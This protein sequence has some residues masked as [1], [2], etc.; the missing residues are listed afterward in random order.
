MKSSASLEASRPVSWVGWPLLEYGA[1]AASGLQ[2][3]RIS[4]IR[5]E[6]VTVRGCDPA[7]ICPCWRWGG[8]PIAWPCLCNA[9][10]THSL[11]GDRG[12]EQPLSRSDLG[13]NSNGDRHSPT[14]LSPFDMTGLP[15]LWE[16]KESIPKLDPL[17]D[18][19]IVYQRNWVLRG[20]NSNYHWYSRQIQVERRLLRWDFASIYP[21]GKSKDVSEIT[22]IHPRCFS[23][24]WLNLYSWQNGKISRL[25]MLHK[26]CIQLFCPKYSTLHKID[27]AWC[28]SLLGSLIDFSGS[29]FFLFFRNENSSVRFLNYF[30]IYFKYWQK[31]A[32]IRGSGAPI[33]QGK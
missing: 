5:K 13:L 3:A 30:S 26:P 1:Q 23:S 12:E 2:S 14:K 16:S 17:V 33:V 15:G 8:N 28:Y 4:L 31:T 32:L 24:S 11:L 6:E 7:E 10:S 18:A 19:S 22:N 25:S 27:A 29:N 20:L 21:A 9:S